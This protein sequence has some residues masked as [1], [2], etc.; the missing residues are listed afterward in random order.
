[1]LIGSELERLGAVTVQTLCLEC[2]AALQKSAYTLQDTYSMP[3]DSAKCLY[4]HY[5]V[6][7]Q[8]SV[9]GF[10]IVASKQRATGVK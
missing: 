10:A 9:M 3:S 6:Y 8:R 5:S 2:S 4:V 1:M 7:S